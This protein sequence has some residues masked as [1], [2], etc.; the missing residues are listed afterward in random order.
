MK[1]NRATFRKSRTSVTLERM[2]LGRLGCGASRGLV[3]PDPVYGDPE[4][5][6]NARKNEH[7]GVAQARELAGAEGELEAVDGAGRHVERGVPPYGPVDGAQE[8][9]L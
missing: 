8:Q 5:G 2:A 3:S 9:A 6:G 7:Q 4:Q 1:K